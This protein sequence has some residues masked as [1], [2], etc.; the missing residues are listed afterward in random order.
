MCGGIPSLP[1][2]LQDAQK[3]DKYLIAYFQINHMRQYHSILSF[4]FREDI[5][6]K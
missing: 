3:A 6:E 4:F 1:W 5:S 2:A